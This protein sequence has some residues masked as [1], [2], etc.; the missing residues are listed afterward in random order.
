MALLFGKVERNLYQDI[1][2]GRKLND[3]KRSYQIL[4]GINARQF[5]S[6]HA[7]IKGKIAS[8]RECLDRQI[9]E[10][11]A[12]VKEVEATIKKLRKR[13]K[14]TPLACPLYK[15]I[16]TPRQNLKWRLHQKHRR[17]KRLQDKL[18][19]IQKVKPSIVF[20]GRK[21]WQA[22]YEL[23]ANGYK[24]HADWKADWQ[25]A[26][27]SQ[28]LCVGSLDE[29]SGCRN[30]Q[31]STNGT[32]KIRVPYCLES[33]F[34][35]YVSA[36]TIEFAYGQADILYALNNKQS[37]TW[38]FVCKEATWYIFCTVNVPEVPKASHK[39]RGMLGIDFNPNLIG[40]AYCD[41]AGNLKAN[42]QIPLNLQDRSTSH[43][44]SSIGECLQASGRFSRTLRLS[45]QRGAFRLL[46]KEG[47]PSG[48]GRSIL[49]DAL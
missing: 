36:Q 38:R 13:L 5:N 35:E 16:H 19:R 43:A 27:S 47:N 24:S 45:Y 23:Q 46:A 44:K 6:I 17:L 37:L 1:Q 21:L 10:L 40:W 8:R 2:K 26:R 20:G 49:P 15:G 30:C 22:Q 18:G 9:K 11:K 4:Y 3:L 48:K 29:P 39:S 42:G 31:Y 14:N 7:S 34:G 33:Q 12:Q 25:Q 28:F 41:A 32:L